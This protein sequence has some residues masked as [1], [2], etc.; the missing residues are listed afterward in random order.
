MEKYA[1][2]KT[3]VP[4]LNRLLEGGL[5]PHTVTVVVGPAGAGKTTIA[6]QFIRRGLYDSRE[7]I[8]VS[9]DETKDQIIKTA[10]NMGFVDIMDYVKDEKLFFIDVS[11]KSFREYINDEL[12]V[13]VNDWKAADTIIAID[14]LTPVMWSAKERYEQ[15]EL[16]GTL[17]KLTKKIGTV[18]ATLEEHSYGMD[19]DVVVPTYLA[20]TAVRLWQSHASGPSG[21][22]VKILKARNTHH[23]RDEHPYSILKGFGIVVKNSPARKKEPGGA[24]QFDPDTILGDSRLSALEPVSRARVLP[25]LKLLK[26]YRYEN[27][28]TDDIIEGILD[29]FNE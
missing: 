2:I 29:E 10:I 3:G 13:L 12:P 4:G 6:T 19:A 5:N 24:A 17:F 27:I 21:R 25:L 26:N 20:D 11:G 7:C 8:F 1:K 22:M 23:S 28:N 15:R 9:L 16:V 14:P 18:L